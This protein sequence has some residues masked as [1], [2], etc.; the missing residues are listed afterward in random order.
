MNTQFKNGLSILFAIL[1]AGMMIS[2]GEDSLVSTDDI[3]MPDS[4]IS[5]RSVNI[6]NANYTYTDENG[7][8]ASVVIHAIE[9]TN[10][11]NVT[12]W[13]SW[14]P[15]VNDGQPEYD[16]EVLC[17]I[18]AYQ[19]GCVNSGCFE[20]YSAI[21]AGVTTLPNGDEIYL[22][23]SLVDDLHNNIQFAQVPYTNSNWYTCDI[24]NIPTESYEVNGQMIILAP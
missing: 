1:I 2:C 23:F 13:I 21:V 11:G 18:T 17:T 20:Y 12:G 8:I 15:N 14:D 9:N 22:Y 10:N 4:R 6:V 24:Q 5:V 3:K 7:F 19:M 16:A